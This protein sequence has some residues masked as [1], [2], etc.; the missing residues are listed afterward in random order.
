MREHTG[1]G[2]T[3]TAGAA[4]FPVIDGYQFVE[5]GGR[6]SGVWPVAEFERLRDVLAAG[7]GELDYDLT[8][9][10]DGFGRPALGLKVSGTLQLACQRC[11]GALPFELRIDA[12]LLLAR[13]EAEIEARTADPDGPD[14]VVGSK[15][16][17][18][19]ALLEDE[20]LLAIPLAPRHEHCLNA[21]AVI[22]E[23]NASPFADLRTLLDQRGRAKN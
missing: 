22:G 1:T 9:T 14:S 10:R 16:M 18:V 3:N 6:L 20:I 17:F 2:S 4:R 13:D 12:M 5:A 21:G 11:L 23:A 7:T 19:G 15:E 8:G